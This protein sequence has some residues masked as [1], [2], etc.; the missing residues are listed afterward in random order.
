MTQKQI[1]KVRTRL[2]NAYNQIIDASTLDI[3][4]EIVELELLLEKE[5][6]K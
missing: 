2:Q 3:V 4:Y 1:D 6:N 5:S